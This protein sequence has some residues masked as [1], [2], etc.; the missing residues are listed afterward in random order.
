LRSVGVALRDSSG[1]FRDLDDVFLELSEKWND[2][3]KNTQRYIATIAAGSRQQ[4][5]FIAMMSDYKR[6]QELVTAAN[7]SAGA[8]QEQF[9]KTLEGITAKLAKLKNA[10][11]EFS[12]SILDSEL[13]K[14]GIDILT[15]FLEIL[16]KATNTLGGFGDSISKILT[17][18]AVFKLGKNVFESL[19]APLIAFFADIVKEAGLAGENAG[20]AAQD[21]LNKSKES[22]NNTSE[23]GDEKEKPKQEGT[24][25]P[26]EV[27]RPSRT[28]SW[29][30]L[31]D[32]QKKLWEGA[33]KDA[34]L[35]T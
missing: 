11:D 1:Q 16:N 4:S 35:K 2:L 15:K 33:N 34:E 6:T 5:R 31:R 19:R 12:M 20:K 28:E 25:T 13:V 23:S 24:S 8:S 32:N 26:A 30:N 9:D 21:G 18:I 22:S 27:P 29:K 3:D 17:I 14:I 10:W 7:N